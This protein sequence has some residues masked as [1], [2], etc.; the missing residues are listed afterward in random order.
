MN[1]ATL[2]RIGSLYATSARAVDLR[3]RTPPLYAGGS[4]VEHGDGLHSFRVHRRLRDTVRNDGLHHLR[5]AVVH[6]T[7]T[8]QTTRLARGSIY[9][10]LRSEERRVGKEW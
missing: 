6:M 7:D 3:N 9:V 8:S 5:L 2:S 4:H 1:I 10:A